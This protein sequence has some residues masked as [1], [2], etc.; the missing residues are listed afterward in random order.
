MKKGHRGPEAGMASDTEGARGAVLTAQAAAS[1]SRVSR[2]GPNRS[3]GKGHRGKSQE[4]GPPQVKGQV[5]SH[6]AG[7]AGET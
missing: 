4:E 6:F 5:K 1:R 3:L 7:C 2:R